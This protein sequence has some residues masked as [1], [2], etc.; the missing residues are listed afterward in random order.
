MLLYNSKIPLTLTYLVV[1]RV[2][3]YDVITGYSYASP[4]M[5]ETLIQNPKT[6]PT[7]N[8]NVFHSVTE[9]SIKILEISTKF[10]R[11]VMLIV[12]SDMQHVTSRMKWI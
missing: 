8:L 12:Q 6:R 9:P 2:I 1:D 7:Y 10:P 11:C 4:R 5:K 3:K